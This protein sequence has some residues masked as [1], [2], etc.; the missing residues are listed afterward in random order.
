MAHSLGVTGVPFPVIDRRYGIAGAQPAETI[1]QVLEQV[2]AERKPDE[3]RGADFH[4]TAVEVHQVRDS[5][6][7]REL[8]RGTREPTRGR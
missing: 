3:V 7:T 6:D 4:V 8:T 1:A 2:W 5:V